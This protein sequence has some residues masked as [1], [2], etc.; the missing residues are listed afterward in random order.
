MQIIEIN[1]LKQAQAEIFEIGCDSAGIQIMSRKAISKAIK[2]KKV[3]TP[4]ALILKQ[5]MLAL[6]GDAVNARGVITGQREPADLLLLGTLAQYQK[7]ITKLQEQSFGLDKLGLEL[8]KALRLYQQKPSGLLLPSGKT[9]NLEKAVIMGILNCT[10]DSFSDGGQFSNQAQA[11]THASQMI[12]DGA[13]IIDVGGESSRPGA[14]PVSEDEEL[15]RVLSVIE[16]LAP[17]TI[18]SIDTTKAIVAQKALKAGAQ[19]VND[20][21]ALRGDTRMAGI[22]AEAYCPVVLMHMQE[23]PQTMQ[24]APAY[25]DIM[26]ELSYFFEER[27]EFA[28]K[29]GIAEEKIILDPGIGFGKTTEHNLT[30]LN[31]LEQLQIFGRPI[32][33]GTS[34]KSVI[35]NILNASTSD[36]LE[37][38]AATVCLGVFK[39]AKIIRVHDVQAMSRVIKMTEAIINEG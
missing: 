31:C 7:L 30:I 33:L 2:I 35:G 24:E 17:Q 10:P 6:G 8:G 21:T 15:A 26:S 5:E 23:T 38:T 27:I 19:I 1:S 9:L 3:T 4:A 20:I 12:Q 37:G 39:N 13:T 14:Q 22:V 36:R 11:V 29:S 32:M 25:T 34:R 18:I 16:K 28:L